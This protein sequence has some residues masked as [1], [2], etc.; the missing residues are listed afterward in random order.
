MPG[1]PSLNRAEVS[2][3]TWRILT[4]PWLSGE[5]ARSYIPGQKTWKHPDPLFNVGRNSE[6]SLTVSTFNWG[7]G[8]SICQTVS[9]FVAGIVLMGS[10]SGR[11]FRGIQWS[12]F[13]TPGHIFTYLW[14]LYRTTYIK[15]TDLLKFNKL[16]ITGRVFYSLDGP[17]VVM[18][19]ARSARV[20]F[21]TFPIIFRK[22]LEVCWKLP[23][24]SDQSSK[25]FWS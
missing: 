18:H 12:D 15:Q 7:T 9:R 20:I 24:I 5:V 25:M 13:R 16:Q 22:M 23:N 14:T 21:H 2:R 17:T 4:G 10:L 11:M 3:Q 8:S 19:L 6:G 1:A